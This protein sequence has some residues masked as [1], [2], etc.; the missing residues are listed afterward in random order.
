VSVF[1]NSI[2]TAEITHGPKD[3]MPALSTGGNGKYVA[4]ALGVAHIGVPSTHPV[5]ES[6]QFCA[7]APTNS[8][9]SPSQ[10]NISN[11]R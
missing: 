5:A 4:E 1:T 10:R 3:I 9:V 6:Q 8:A 11:N 7:P 2:L